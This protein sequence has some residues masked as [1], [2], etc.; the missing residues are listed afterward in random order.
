VS[1]IDAAR[2]TL[3]NT[4]A[5]GSD[6]ASLAITPD[7][8]K[9]YVA[10]TPATS[11]A[12][13]DTSRNEVVKNITV[14]IGGSNTDVAISESGSAAYVADAEKKTVAVIDT[15][16]D[17][18]TDVKRATPWPASVELFRR[19]APGVVA[20][21]DGRRVYVLNSGFGATASTTSFPEPL[22]ALDFAS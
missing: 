9:L 19:C 5:V 16:S 14:G 18:V 20:S 12:V 3:L 15:S 21:P 1:V 11:V 10:G 17:I 7:G 22:A 8:R 4:I 2:G 13:I 6:A